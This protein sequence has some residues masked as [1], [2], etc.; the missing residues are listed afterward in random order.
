MLAS[1]CAKTTKVYK[2]VTHGFD[3]MVYKKKRC[4]ELG[5]GK[6]CML[7]DEDAHKKSTKD[8]KSFLNEVCK[9]G[10]KVLT[11]T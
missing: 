4:S 1:N 10:E 3:N 8:I 2:G 11:A 9:I 5:E 6:H 7:Y